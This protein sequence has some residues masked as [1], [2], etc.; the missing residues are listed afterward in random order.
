MFLVT[1]CVIIYCQICRHC[2]CC[3]IALQQKLLEE[4]GGKLKFKELSLSRSHTCI[5]LLSSTTVWSADIWRE[6]PW[7]LLIVRKN[8]CLPSGSA[9][10]SFF[11]EERDFSSWGWAVLRLAGCSATL[12]YYC[13]SF[14]R[15]AKLYESLKEHGH[16]LSS[17]VFRLGKQLCINL[18]GNIRIEIY[19]CL[20]LESPRL[21]NSWFYQILFGTPL[22][23][24]SIGSAAGTSF[25]ACA[26]GT[27]RQVVVWN[28][29]APILLPDSL[30]WW[31]QILW[32]IWCAKREPDS[33]PSEPQWPL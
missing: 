24:A 28:H 21:D 29:L 26:E 11:R 7:L 27:E 13:L 32:V 3:V 16:G 12:V 33:V 1:S 17:L 5:F 14:V 20:T 6:R 30:L 4:S 2:E 9:A 15:A 22:S 25:M 23:A 19:F 18:D 8:Q 31:P 10:M